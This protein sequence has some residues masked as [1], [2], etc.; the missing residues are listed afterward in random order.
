MPGTCGQ[1]YGSCVARAGPTA[2]AST[3]GTVTV[4]R[5][6]ST[7]IELY[8]ED[9]GAGPPVVLVHGFPLNCHAWEKQTIALLNAGHRVIV[10]DRRGFGASSQ[11]TTGYDFHTLASD[12]NTLVTTLDLQEAVF[13]GHDMGTGEVVRYL[14]S[15]GSKRVT[16]AILISPLQPGLLKSLDNP[17]GV[18]METFENALEELARD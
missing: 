8:Y 11:P 9:H 10:Y 12:L 3:M 4:G 16:R 1:S 13:A 5:E 17:R 14:S 7:P 15:Y 6:N 2:Y 18:E